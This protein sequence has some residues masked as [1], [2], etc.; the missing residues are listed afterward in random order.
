MTLSNKPLAQITERDLLQLIEDKASESKTIEYKGDLVASSDSE[1][2]E[3]LYATSSFANTQG[4]HIVFGMA[5]ASGL[6]TKL[7]DLAGIDPDK[8]IQRLEQILRHG[9]RP[10]LAIETKPVRLASGNVALVMRIAKSWN[11]PHQV[12]L[13]KAFRFYR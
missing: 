6:P 7:E 4:G 10:S 9:V 3:F 2:K 13:Q 8:E 11:P 12:T 5:E 1:K